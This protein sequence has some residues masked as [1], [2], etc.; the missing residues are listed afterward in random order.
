MG[1]N[2]PPNHETGLLESEPHPEYPDRLKQTIRLISALK[3]PLQTIEELKGSPLFDACDAIVKQ[4]DRNTPQAQ[5]ERSAAAVAPTVRRPEKDT[6]LPASLAK[7]IFPNIWK[8]F[9]KLVS[10]NFDKFAA[11]TVAASLQVMESAYI[12]GTLKP[13]HFF[14]HTLDKEGQTARANEEYN[15]N[16]IARLGSVHSLEL[17]QIPP[18]EYPTPA[19]HAETL[20]V[21]LAQSLVQYLLNQID[22]GG[23]TP[24]PIS[25]PDKEYATRTRTTARKIL[26]H[27]KVK[28][29]DGLAS[30]ELAK[31]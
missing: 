12:Q 1:I 16:C 20:Q 19:E 6:L 25:I 22:M 2:H 15:Q 8:H 10:A 5:A 3:E 18:L 9:G 11:K 28:G 27:L 29:W 24:E 30:P 21:A 13:V 26:E 7:E 31:N 23:H 4:F 17:S 14:S